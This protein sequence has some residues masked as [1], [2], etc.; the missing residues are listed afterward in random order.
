VAH[1]V[2]QLN[3]LSTSSLAMFQASSSFVSIDLTV[4]ESYVASTRCSFQLQPKKA[5]ETRWETLCINLIGPYK[6]EAAR[7]CNPDL[8]LHC[9]IMIDP[10]IG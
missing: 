1:H 2:A 4:L 6:I 9:L 7:K 3:R 8:I 5:E 10:M